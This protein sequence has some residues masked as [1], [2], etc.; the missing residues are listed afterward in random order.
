MITKEF[1]Q[2]HFKMHNKIVLYS[3]DNIP[4]T[5]SKEYHLHLEGGHCSMDIVD[6]ED[7]AEFCEK[8]GLSLKPQ[9]I[10]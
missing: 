2:K 6:C 4:L 8:T 1:L 5:I 3:K 7:L 10:Q 9:D